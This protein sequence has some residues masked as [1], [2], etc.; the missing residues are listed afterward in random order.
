MFKFFKSAPKPASTARPARPD[1]APLP[2]PSA[3]SA[4]SARAGMPPAPP[5]L[6]DV[7]E[8]NEESDWAMWEDSVAFQ[9]SQMPSVFNE[10]DAVKTR[11][12]EP[13]KSGSPDPY[14]TV[15]RRGT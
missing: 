3:P 1:T 10:L 2:R 8:G 15:R 14:S 11:D 7:S 12:E 9:D 6:P 5:P 13:K 4:A